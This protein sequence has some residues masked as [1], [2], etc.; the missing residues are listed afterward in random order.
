MDYHMYIKHANLDKLERKIAKLKKINED[1][2]KM[3]VSGD[4]MDHSYFDD[5]MDDSDITLQDIIYCFSES[6]FY[7]LIQGT[8]DDGSKCCVISVKRY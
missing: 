4:I 3:I 6:D 1:L 8:N 5:K 7:Q 2:A